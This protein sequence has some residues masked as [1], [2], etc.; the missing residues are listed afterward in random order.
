MVLKREVGREGRKRGRGGGCEGEI[1]RGGWRCCCAWPELLLLLLKVLLQ[2]MW[3]VAASMHTQLVC[4]PT[5]TRAPTV[6]KLASAQ[7]ASAG[8]ATAQL[9]PHL[10][11]S[12]LVSSPPQLHAEHKDI[13]ISN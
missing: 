6:I 3:D 10:G 13:R 5:H 9:P 8:S 2:M 7:S 1:E 12:L 4:K 11:I